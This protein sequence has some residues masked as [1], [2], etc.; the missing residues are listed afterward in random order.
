I[1]LQFGVAISTMITG[2]FIIITR[3]KLITHIMGYMII[4]NGIFLLTLSAAKEMP[5]IVSLGVSLDI[6]VGVLMTGL[7][8]TKIKSNFEDED[9]DSLSNLKD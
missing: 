9:I 1:P 2:M 5:V 3:R 6:F 4:E 7:F 8:I